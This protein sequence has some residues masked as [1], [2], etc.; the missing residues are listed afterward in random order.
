MVAYCDANPNT[1]QQDIGAHVAQKADGKMIFT[2]SVLSQH[3]LY[4]GWEK[5]KQKAD[6]FPTALSSKG[7]QA[8]THP[9]MDKTLELWQKHMENVKGE[10][11]KG[12]MLMEK[13]ARFAKQ[14]NVP[15]SDE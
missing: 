2:Q 11:V 7:G 8:V 5:D 3:L 14:M 6:A 1:S 15:A 4:Q 9:N 10:Q 12:A 13:R